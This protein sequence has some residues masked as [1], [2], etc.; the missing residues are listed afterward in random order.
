MSTSLEDMKG[1]VSNCCGAQVYLDQMI[2]SD[3]KEHCD[4]E[5]GE[6]EDNTVDMHVLAGL[7]RWG[8]NEDGEQEWVGTHKQWETYKKLTDEH[9]RN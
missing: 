4:I 8:K 1:G 5:E 9:D 6:V 7:Q 3:C 2:C